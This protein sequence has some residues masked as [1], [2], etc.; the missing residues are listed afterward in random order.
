MNAPKR[1][2]RFPR[3]TLTLLSNR[4]GD[5]QY[6]K[7]NTISLSPDFFNYLMNPMNPDS[8]GVPVPS[9][10][11]RSSRAEAFGEEARGGT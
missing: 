10:F 4:D 6:L 5:Q 9:S 11:V 2:R 8:V 1:F 3:F 7:E